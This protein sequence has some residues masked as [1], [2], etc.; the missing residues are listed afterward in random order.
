MGSETRNAEIK[1]GQVD[2]EIT[3]DNCIGRTIT[4][5]NA[6]SIQTVEKSLTDNIT[7]VKHNVFD[8]VADIILEDYF[9]FGRLGV[10]LSPLD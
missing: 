6:L 7:G 5:E 9:V 4:N 2:A 10:L 8:T 3:S 1:N